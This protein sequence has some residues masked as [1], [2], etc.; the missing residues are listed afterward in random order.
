MEPSKDAVPEGKATLLQ[1]A[2]TMLCG[3][4]MIGRKDSWEKG[5]DAA[6]MTPGQIVGGAI[7]GGIVVVAALIGLVSI[8]LG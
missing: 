4:V 3:L 2:K 5:G 8:V 7:V 1:V 6:L